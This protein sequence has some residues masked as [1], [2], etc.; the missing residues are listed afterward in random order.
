MRILAAENRVQANHVALPVERFE[1]MRDGEQVHFG[2][3]FVRRVSPVAVGE[4][5]ELSRAD[6]FLEPLLHGAHLGLAVVRPRRNR[7]RDARGARGIRLERA[8]HVHP[9][10]R[11]QVVEVDH[12]ILNELHP[13][14][15]VA[16]RVRVGRNLDVERV[17]DRPAARDR[18]HDGAHAANA[19]RER[20]CVARIA[21]LHDRF[22]AAELRGRR[23]RLCDLA[24]LGLRFD[25][26]VALDPRDGIDD[27]LGSSHC[28]SP[29]HRRF[30]GSAASPCGA[31]SA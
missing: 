5:A 9:I 19:L 10:E 8:R 20:P 17:L 7:L 6:E 28:A 13:V 21:A 14:N 24:V 3:Q 2:R 22:D 26:Q 29:H 25:A 30:R 1:I 16:N 11:V 15:Q 31:G 27:D 18:V 4:N 12:V 23:P